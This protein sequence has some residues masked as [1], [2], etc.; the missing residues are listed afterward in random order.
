MA[1]SFAA[2]DVVEIAIVGD[3]ADT[4]T[5]ELLA[6]V[7]STWRPQQVLAVAPPDREADSAVPLVRDR[8]AIDGR[9][10]AYVCR[11]FACNLPVTDPA[12]LA[13]QLRREPATAG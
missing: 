7:W 5:H 3:P 1:A 13:D 4:A 10:T 9:A 12:A 11:D 2:S 8:V 6:P